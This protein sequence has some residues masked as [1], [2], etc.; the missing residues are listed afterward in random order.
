M[1]TV[2]EKAKTVFKKR[3]Y[4]LKHIDDKNY[5][6]QKNL[7][8]VFLHIVCTQGGR[9]C[10]MGCGYES[11]SGTCDTPGWKL[12]NQDMIDNDF[13]GIKRL[14]LKRN[15]PNFVQTS[16]YCLQSWRAN[17]DVSLLIYDSDPKHP[18]ASEIAKV[19]DYVVGYACKG[20]ETL[21]IERKQ[22]KDFMLG[23]EMETG[24]EN[25]IIRV[26]QKCL[27]K[28]VA[29]RT[30]SK[31]EA[32]CLLGKLPLVICSEFIETISLSNATRVSS[33]H[34]TTYKTIIA[35]YNKR[36]DHLDMSLHQFFHLTKNTNS[37]KNN[38]KEIVP[39]YVGGGGQP[40]YP[41]SKN[42]ARVEMLKHIP[43]SD[44]HLLPELNDLTTIPLFEEFLNSDHCPLSVSISLERAK[45]RV[46]MRKKGID[47]PIS[48]EIIHPTQNSENIDEDT[49]HLLC[50]VSNLLDSNNIFDSSENDGF[51]IGRNNIWGKRINKVSTLNLHFYKPAFFRISEYFDIPQF[52]Y[53]FSQ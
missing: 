39:H 33:G 51:D 52:I 15:H 8:K 12:I 17:C 42:F 26:V 34:D 10:R 28:S 50:I 29:N 48:E 23:C 46:E 43:W 2:Y 24:D 31:Q 18:D 5:I 3:R 36:K 11:K 47:E 49:K 32:V 20:N 14:F 44:C 37:S 40:K 19:T 6:M 7:T 16:L 27:N 25:D 35:K 9:Q 1:T 21:A 4:V 13:K 30:T 38:K 45:N 22:V 41:I 53:Y